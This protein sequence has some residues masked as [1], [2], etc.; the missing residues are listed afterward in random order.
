MEAQQLDPSRGIFSPDSLVK[1]FWD[2]LMFAWIIWQAISVP[3]KLCFDQVGSSA[4]ASQNFDYFIDVCFL[5][6]IF[7]A[8]N[9]GYYKNGVLI[10]NR[11]MIVISYLKSW[12]LIDLV[13]TFPYAYVI[14]WSNPTESSDLNT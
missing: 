8:F 3:F 6:D 2:L 10:M 12:F 14:Q 9:T 7:I 5:L 4:E 11:K 13:A 1:S